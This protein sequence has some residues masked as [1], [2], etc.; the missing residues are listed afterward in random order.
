LT[1]SK[2]ATLMWSFKR[3][4]VIGFVERYVS[5]RITL[6]KR[7]LSDIEIIL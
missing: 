4:R 7:E 3:E 1:Y 2:G 5:L 6:S